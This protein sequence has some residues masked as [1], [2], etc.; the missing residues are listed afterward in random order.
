MQNNATH[1]LMALPQFPLGPS[2][3][4]VNPSVTGWQNDSDRFLL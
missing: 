1:T 2:G 4:G 3:I